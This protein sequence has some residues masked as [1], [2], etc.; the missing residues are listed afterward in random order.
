M[1]YRKEYQY[2]L[3]IIMGKTC[4]GKNAVVK[5][6]V[7]R[8]WS[9]IITYT[10]RPKRRGEKNGREYFY[11][12][13]DDFANKINSGYFAEWKSYNVNGKTWYYG[14]PSEEIIE[15]SLDDK[16]NVI[17][18][19]PQG[20][21]DTLAFLSKY[22]SDYQINIIYLY[23]NRST[24]LNRLQKRK[25]KNDSIERRMRADDI[26]FK[27]ATSLAN[28]IIYNND[29]DSVAEVADKIIKSAERKF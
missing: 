29:S 21:E 5:E 1:I 9:Q 13:N 2:L 24:I 14:S 25:D 28:K 8:G 18:L 23:A 22:I 15:A 26:D 17:I 7:S 19:T 4:S 12:S 6:L 10:S 16:N 20:V 11:I 3:T 27:N